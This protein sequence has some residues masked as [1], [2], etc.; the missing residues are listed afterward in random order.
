MTASV[1]NGEGD[2]DPVPLSALQHYLFCPRQCAL[3]HVERQ[4]AENRFTAE[5]R[6]L[7]EAADI[8]SAVSRRDLKVVRGMPI[9]SSPLGV[10]G[11][12]DV[13]ELWREVGRWRPF[14]VEYKRGRP[15]AHR[16]DE[17]QLCAQALCLEE[18]FATPVPEGALFYGKTRRRLGVAFDDALRALTREVASRTREMIAGGR[19]PPPI[20]DKGR[21]EPCSLIE[22]C[23]PKAMQ[24][25]GR[26]GLWLARQIAATE[27][28]G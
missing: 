9:A 18:M 22:L 5:G 28:G 16:A 10:A 21:C 14:P 12:A 26:V 2:G 27:D 13:V 7:H 6:I 1:G 17:V 15:K 4:W 11:V 19:T 8:P 20:Y 23:R 25:R 24:R 3:I